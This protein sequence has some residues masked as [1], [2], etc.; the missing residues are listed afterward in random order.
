MLKT[1][2]HFLLKFESASHIGRRKS[3]P[4]DLE[5]DRAPGAILFSKEYRAHA[6]LAQAS[7]DHIFADAFGGLGSALVK[8]CD[9]I[10]HQCRECGLLPE[11][12]G[13]LIV[14]AQERFDRFAQLSIITTTRIQH[15]LAR[16]RAFVADCKKDIGDTLVLIG[17]HVET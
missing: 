15:G 11:Q 7:N 16:I 1:G 5:S 12:G 6:A 14:M 2:E 9:E 13:W 8:R 3:V 10:A 17:R 4:H